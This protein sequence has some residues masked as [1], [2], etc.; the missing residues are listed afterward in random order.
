M[1]EWRPMKDAPRGV[2]IICKGRD[3]WPDSARTW[4]VE[5][6]KFASDDSLGMPHS[7]VNRSNKG[8]GFTVGF[9]AQGWIPVPKDK[10]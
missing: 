8:G 6:K 5:C 7:H 10:P 1:A 3:N 9:T 2:P 4:I